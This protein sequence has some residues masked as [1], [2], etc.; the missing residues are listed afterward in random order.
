M[1]AEP[2]AG[3][4][5][6]EMRKLLARSKDGGMNCAVGV[7]KDQQ[8]MLLLHKTKAGPALVKELEKAAG[9]ALKSPAHGTALVDT[10]QDPKLVVLTLNKAPSGIGA[11]LKKTL[12][13]TGFT[14][15]M[16]K[17][18][19]GTIAEMVDEEDEE[20]KPG[21]SAPPSASSAEPAKLAAAPAQATD[22][23]AALKR[24]VAG[25]IGRIAA[26]GADDP[27]RKALLLKLA[28]DANAAFKANDVAGA[29]AIAAKL[30]DALDTPA[31]AAAKPSGPKPL[32]VWTEA[33]EAALGHL[34]T[35]QSALRARKSTL[36]DQVADKGLNGIT[37]RLQVGM[38]VALMEVERAG[39]DS[40]DAARKK[41]LAAVGAMRT[42]LQSDQTLSLLEKN[43][44]KVPMPIRAELGRALDQI[45]A[46]L[47]T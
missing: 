6:A 15:A 11:K 24:A 8:A 30:R 46:S 43:P 17:L 41:A 42:F 7:G 9:G 39:G 33:K 12:K 40:R 21:A 13:G 2:N 5:K 18:D 20:A 3:M 38:Q 31:P 19:D 34:G 27:H 26:E 37:G 10:D 14:K 45:E 44:F 25:L 29:A 22:Q 4:D 23:S 35:L 36:L 47:T 28:G 1:A 16:I 32:E